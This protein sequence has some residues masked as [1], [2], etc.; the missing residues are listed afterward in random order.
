MQPWQNQNMPNLYPNMWKIFFKTLITFHILCLV[1]ADFSAVC[2]I[3][4]KKKNALKLYERGD[5]RVMLTEVKPN[6]RDLIS[7]HQPQGCRCI[8][9]KYTMFYILMISMIIIHLL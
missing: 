8:K 6:I 2:Q 5:T 3:L 1:E 7:K 9:G 4:T